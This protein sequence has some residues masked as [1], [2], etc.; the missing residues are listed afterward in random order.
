MTQSERS[1]VAESE[2]IARAVEGDRPAYGELYERYL[3][4]IYRY[5]YYSVNDHDEA[6][7]LTEIVFLKAWE[8]LPRFRRARP[9]FQAW[10]YRI[11]HNAV[12][13]RYR[14][15]KPEVSLEQFV[16]L[17]DGSPMPESV[18]EMDQEIERLAVALGQLKPHWRQVVICR[19]ISGLSHAETAKVTGLTQGHVRVLQYRA[20]KQLRRL[21]EEDVERDD[22]VRCRRPGAMP[23]G[24]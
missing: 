9:G 4:R 6:E 23:A 14:T 11:A 19:F 22:Q 15:R 7:D 16:H 3:D 20:L 13:D 10:V 1:Q 5:I 12:I 21:L 2:L 8:A 18:V 24:D 17:R